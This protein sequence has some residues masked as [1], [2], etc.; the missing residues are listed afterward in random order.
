MVELPSQKIVIFSSQSSTVGISITLLYSQ[1]SSCRNKNTLFYREPTTTNIV[2][3]SLNNKTRPLTSLYPAYSS[4]KK[5]GLLLPHT[6]HFF[7]SAHKEATTRSFLPFNCTINVPS[8]NRPTG[9]LT[10]RHHH[11]MHG[12]KA[13]FAPLPYPEKKVRALSYYSFSGKTLNGTPQSPM[14]GQQGAE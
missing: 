11:G 8:A 14:P 4:Q 1:M 3:F 10:V 6:M 13:S 9:A 5:N 7:F 2:H 12:K